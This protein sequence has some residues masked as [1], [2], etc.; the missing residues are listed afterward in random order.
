MHCCQ[1]ICFSSLRAV[2]DFDL[3]NC[4]IINLCYFKPLSLWYFVTVA[5]ENKQNYL[6]IFFSTIYDIG[7][8]LQANS[9]LNFP[10]VV[11]IVL[12]IQGAS[13]SFVN[14]TSSQVSSVP[15][16]L[17]FSPFCHAFLPSSQHL[18]II[19]SFRIQYLVLILLKF[20][21]SF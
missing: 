11:K 3:Q 7:L 18:T 6:S 9:C 17:A 4:K 15:V 10:W 12:I 20:Y 21:F 19:Q 16:Y 13:Q 1:H 2:S 8:F 14:H 5:I